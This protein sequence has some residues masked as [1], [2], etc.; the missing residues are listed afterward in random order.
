MQ[1][2]IH[3]SWHKQNLTQTIMDLN[4]KHKTIKLLEENPGKKICDLG[5]GKDLLDMT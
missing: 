1:K 5:L 2:L 4:V 3:I